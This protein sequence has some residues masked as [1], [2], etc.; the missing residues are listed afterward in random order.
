MER[1]TTGNEYRTPAGVSTA[2]GR[3]CPSLVFHV[4]MLGIYWQGW[5]WAVR[6]EYDGARWVHGS[7]RVVRALESVGVRLDIENL[8]V[9]GRLEGPAVFIANH[10]STLETFVLPGLIHP[11]RKIVFVIKESLL[12]FPFFGKV[13]G[14]RNPISVGRKNP[15][16]DLRVVLEEGA[17]RLAGGLSVV[18]FPQTTR[19]RIF[20]PEQFNTIGI[21][22]AKRAGVPVVP[23]ALKTD[24][25]GVGRP[26]KDFG[27]IHPEKTAHLAF[28][29][30]MTIEE[31]GRK[32]HDQVV[33][34]IRGKLEEWGEG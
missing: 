3:C 9:P 15:R 25:W 12:R 14:A 8:G 19:S 21:K 20:I 16:D 26:L 6:G 18:V 28:G 24:A 5:R 11:D 33:G 32:Q 27:P 22:L 4:R 2:L 30:P 17:V 1:L 7:L 31:N 23:V 13:I 29:E 10:M 34:F